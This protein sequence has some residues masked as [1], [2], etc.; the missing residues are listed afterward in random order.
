MCI[1]LNQQVPAISDKLTDILLD[2]N[3]LQVPN[4]VS[5]FV[6]C[7]VLKRSSMQTVLRVVVNIEDDFCAFQKSLYD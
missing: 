5:F 1:R 4:A 7:P 6:I 3:A 2:L